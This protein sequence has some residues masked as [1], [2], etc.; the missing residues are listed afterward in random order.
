M[1]L[2][3]ASTQ[4]ANRPADER[5]WNLAEMREK[6]SAIKKDGREITHT[7]NRLRA[8]AVDGGTG[9]GLLLEGQENKSLAALTA[10]SFGQLC[11]FVAPENGKKAD[12]EYLSRMPARIAADALNHDLSHCEAESKIL[13]NVDAPGEVHARAFNT[14]KYGRYWN[15]EALDNLLPMLNDGWRVPPARPSDQSDPRARPATEAD[16]LQHR[17]N[18]IGIKPG[19]MIAPAGLYMGEKDMFAFLV[20]ETRP[21]D[22]GNGHPMYRGFFYE[23][24]EVGSLSHWITKFLYESVCGNHIVW[25]ASQVLEIRVI[26]RGEKVL[27]R[28]TRALEVIMKEYSDESAS[29]LEAKIKVAQTIVFG[30]NKDE[31][32][33]FLYKNL[34]GAAATQTALEAAYDAAVEHPEDAGEKCAPNSAWGMA[35]GMTRYSQSQTWTDKR[36]ELDRLAGSILDLATGK[37]KH[38]VLEAVA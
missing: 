36:V 19:D 2:M 14:P 22:T 24:S 31:T 8:V 9:D 7:I 4:W 23:N 18:G 11:R 1:N 15:E 3:R 21:I 28:A 10:Y 5:F 33:N 25:C 34:A 35:Q 38:K 13:W 26:H 37:Q 20:N 6:E 12:P 32:V 17:M 29:D 30:A 27:D 16:C